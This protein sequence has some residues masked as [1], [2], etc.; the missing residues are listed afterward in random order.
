MEARAASVAT[1]FLHFW[2]R[3]VIGRNEEVRHNSTPSMRGLSGGTAARS[4]GV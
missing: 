2:N 3:C 1:Q 4:E